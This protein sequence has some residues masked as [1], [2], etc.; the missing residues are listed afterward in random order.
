M[1]A[2]QKEGERMTRILVNSAIVAM[3][4]SLAGPIGC[5]AGAENCTPACSQGYHCSA[6]ACVAGS[7]PGAGGSLDECPGTLPDGPTILVHG[8]CASLTISAANAFLDTFISLAPHAGITLAP[9]FKSG[10]L[11]GFK[12]AYP[13]MKEPYQHVLSLWDTEVG[14]AINA[15][16]NAATECDREQVLLLVLVCAYGEE[17]VNQALSQSNYQSAC[18]SGG[19]GGGSS[20]SGG[21]GV[22]LSEDD[23]NDTQNTASCW[24]SAGCDSYDSGTDTYSYDDYSY[25]PD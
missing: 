25:Y 13:V 7:A 23:Y 24:A 9:D 17:Q 3:L 1:R 8:T 16:W 18:N 6:G 2:S 11:E 22:Y 12:T 15:N 19:G 21:S 5:E 4:A 20:S 10:S 14:P